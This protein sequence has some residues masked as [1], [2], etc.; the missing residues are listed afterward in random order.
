MRRASHGRS[1]GRVPLPAKLTR[2]R[3]DAIVERVRLFKRL[4]A[5]VSRRWC[6]IGAP[7]G[8]GKTTLASSWI[9][10]SGLGCLWVSIDGGDADPASL[11]HYLGL[12]WKAKAGSR[13]VDLPLLTPEFLP[14]LDIF[15]RRF[16][17]QLFC[18]HGRPFAVVL[19]NCHEVP[20]DAPLVQGV[21][22]ALI[23][24]LPVHGCLVCL[25]RAD[26]PPNLVR[27]STEPGCVRLGYE[28]LSFTD[29]E[30][31]ALARLSSPHAVAVVPACNQLVKGWVAG[32]KLLLRARPNEIAH[33][34]SAGAAPQ[35]ELFDYF[36]Q[37]ILKHST[38]KQREF[39]LRCSVLPE[40][41]EE[42]VV[43]VSGRS[44]AGSLL[45]ALYT[46][47]QFI[48]RRELTGRLSYRFHP[49]FR[50]FLRAHLL[51][52][53]GLAEVASLG[54]R[55][56]RLLESRGELEAA[57][58]IALECRD[59]DLLVH[60]ILRQAEALFLQGRWLTLVHW[61]G[62]VPEPLRSV[63]AW[64]LY[65]LGVSISVRDPARGRVELERAHQV[66]QGCGETVGAWLAVAGII[67]NMHILWGADSE[68]REH[69][70]AV[71]EGLQAQNSGRIPESIEP[72]VIVLL[73]QFASHCP[74]HAVS[75]YLAAR[76]RTLALRL[77]DPVQR[78]AVGS[79]AVGFLTWQGDEA[80]ARALVGDLQRGRAEDAPIT[81]GSMVFDIWRGILLWTGAEYERS[82]EL[83]AAAR[84]RCRSS[85]LQLY[86]WHCGVHM[87]LAALGMGDLELMRR[88]V[89][90]AFESLTPEHSNITYAALAV[91]ALH[92]ART[93]QPAAAEQVAR[94]A[95]AVSSIY[96]EAPSVVAFLECVRGS[97]FLELGLL[98]EAAACART[99]LGN[100][101]RLPSDRWAFEAEMLQAGIELER[102]VPEEMQVRLRSALGIAGRR[103]FTGGLA[104]FAS[105]RTG[106]L[107]AL[108][109]G[110]GIEVE[111][112]RRL[113]RSGRFSVPDDPRVA[114]LW[115][116]RLRVRMLGGLAVEVNEQPLT[117]SQ[118]SARKPL[119]VLEALIGLGPQVGLDALQASLW[120]E[121]EGDAARNA[122]HVAIHRLRK[123]LGDDRT[124]QVDKATVRVD[125]HDAWADVD[126]F[127][128][129]SARLQASLAAGIRSP[130][131]AMQQARELLHAYPGHFL[132]SDEQP[133]VVGVRERL[134][135]RFMQMAIGVSAVL[136]RLGA[137]E[138]AIDLN[139]H[140]IDLD[141]YAETF[142]RGLIRNLVA[143]D[144]RA[145]ALQALQRCRDLLHAGL[146]VAPSPETERLVRRIRAD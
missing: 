70:L 136:E 81:L 16:F 103:T 13:R 89:E 49:L 35:R 108:A 12:A 78:C 123:L 79:I 9:D 131:V 74:E 37:E 102:G 20:G 71:F 69:W 101:A 48:E 36:A 2:P 59:A 44:E 51:R 120:P 11:F 17:E 92:L 38:L 1:R 144:R 135:N 117:A 96:H 104:L 27:L 115:P 34:I 68:R 18:L 88:I 145:E 118:R 86:E 73:A 140:G 67:H 97:A 53:L 146:G 83:L 98:D 126:A 130:E 21:L 124:I 66:F 93:G 75:R 142:H 72:Q 33:A 91:Q 100:A 84:L 28:D 64:L 54:T 90:E 14:R 94:A 41:D 85:G 43:A 30:A 24:S 32:L 15:A 25:S 57:T 139:L 22:G 63:N 127:R 95:P 31:T 109:L 105:T 113:I 82:F 60:L 23:E 141:P 40:M 112:A 39:L 42:T 138:V 77:E 6:W 50:D 99:V 29:E 119:E 5:P 55:A 125:M 111:Q 80:A 76:A 134:R 137:T 7:A 87:I 107:L 58:G 45:A 133:W 10:Y 128:H 56:A 46:E 116:V 61:I 26:M 132:P 143:L 110:T 19:D 114:A 62:A 129:S 52:E 3:T 121:L 47:R 106:R 65:W 8:A 4:E 122:C